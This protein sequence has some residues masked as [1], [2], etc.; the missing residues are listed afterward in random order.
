[1]DD[2]VN[3]RVKLS[4]TDQRMK[5][6]RDETVLSFKQREFPSQ[7]VRLIY[8]GRE[9]SDSET[10]RGANIAENDICHAIVRSP[11]QCLQRTLPVEG[12]HAPPLSGWDIL[13][14]VLFMSCVLAWMVAYSVPEI[15]S[16]SSMTLIISISTV[17]SAVCVIRVAK[18]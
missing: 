1:M 12:G 4:E 16:S 17:L 9:I 10:F 7:S 15:M 14:L 3:I 2:T 11:S 8:K 5:V 18:S 13:L 6:Q